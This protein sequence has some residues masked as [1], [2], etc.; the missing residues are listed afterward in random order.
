MISPAQGAQ[1]ECSNN[2]FSPLGGDNMGFAGVVTAFIL[3]Y[4]R[5]TDKMRLVFCRR[6][7]SAD[8]GKSVSSSSPP[9]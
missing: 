3:E 6:L 2:F 9:G 1:Q 7:S 8:T 4:R 5:P